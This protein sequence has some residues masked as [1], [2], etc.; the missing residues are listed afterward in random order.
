MPK[1][2]AILTLA[3]VSLSL[4]P[5]CT[6]ARAPKKPQI[7][8][9]VLVWLKRP[10]NDADRAALIAAARDFEKQIPEIKRLS[11]GRPLRSVRP[12]VDDTFDL[13]FVM[14]FKDSG[15]MTAFEKH[16]VHEKAARDLLHPLARKI[17]VYDIVT[18]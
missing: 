18:E 13:G 9:V 6:T 8:H 7:D 1:V 14:R 11:I 16:A 2:I 3:A 12:S 4:L 10:G 15:S 5:G 17:V